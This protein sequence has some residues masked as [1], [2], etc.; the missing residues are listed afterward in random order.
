[1]G[2]I[3]FGLYIGI[4]GCSLKTAENLKVVGALPLDKLLIETDAPWC[5]IRPTHASC[6]LVASHFPSKRKERWEAGTAV[7]SRNEPRNVVQVLEVLSKLHSRDT[8]DMAEQ[9]Y[10][11]TCKLFNWTD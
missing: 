5:D 9:I 7:K 10:S 2:A 1:M 6:S 3:Q 4:N 11:S 8:L